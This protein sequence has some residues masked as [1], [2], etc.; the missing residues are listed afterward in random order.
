MSSSR[1][2]CLKASNRTLRGSHRTKHTQSSFLADQ[3]PAGADSDKIDK[4]TLNNNV[5][6]KGLKKVATA[7]RNSRG[8]HADLKKEQNNPTFSSLKRS[9]LYTCSGRI[10]TTLNRVPKRVGNKA[11]EGA[12]PSIILEDLSETV[13]HPGTSFTT[14]QQGQQKAMSNRAQSISPRQSYLL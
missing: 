14:R 4:E 1:E 3:Y 5:N 11:G 13:H 7:D 12:S 6:R 10:Y 9:D 2:K 8:T